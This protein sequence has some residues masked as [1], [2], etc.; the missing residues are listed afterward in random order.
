MGEFPNCTFK[1]LKDAGETQ[2]IKSY[3]SKGGSVVGSL[4]KKYAAHIREWKKQGLKVSQIDRLLE[5]CVDPNANMMDI[6]KE[7]EI[8]KDNMSEKDFVSLK[9]TVH[10]TRFGDK[11]II[12]STNIH[13]NIEASEIKE[14]LGKLFGMEDT[15]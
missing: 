7:L 12:Q 4:K 1:K 15:Q 8:A 13:I 10:R 3:G 14:H 6:E 5:R 11:H 9:N 2:A